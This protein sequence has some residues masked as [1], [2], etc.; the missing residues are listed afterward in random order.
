MKI[1]RHA[2]LNKAVGKLNCNLHNLDHQRMVD[3][4]AQGAAEV[5]EAGVKE[6]RGDGGC[7]HPPWQLQ[8]LILHAND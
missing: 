5:E 6:V 1:C 4:L 8:Q 3:Q 2:D 7:R